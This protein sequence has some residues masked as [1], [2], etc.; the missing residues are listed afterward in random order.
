M[1]YRFR[2]TGWCRSRS[3]PSERRLAS[4][5]GPRYPCVLKP[6][7]LSGSRGVI[8]ANDATE[9]VEAFLRIK[10][11]VAKDDSIQVEDFIPGREFALEGLVS[12]QEGCKRWPCSMLQNRIRSTEPILSRKRF[13]PSP[14]SNRAWRGAGVYTGGRATRG[15]GPWPHPGTRARRNAS[16]P[17]SRL[18]AGGCGQADRR[19]VLPGSAIRPGR[20]L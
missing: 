9:F 16:E 13:I 4:A 15:N 6:L 12:R 3:D 10:K 18:D 14:S 20:F 11:L 17:G 8:R 2:A 5:L 1:D 19:V 7:E